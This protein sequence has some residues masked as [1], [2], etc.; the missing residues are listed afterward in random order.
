VHGESEGFM[1]SG[2]RSLTVCLGMS[3]LVPLFDHTVRARCA[4]Y[5]YCSTN[6][7]TIARPHTTYQLPC[8]VQLG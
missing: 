8:A 7:V 2:F 1:S 4:I 6:L 5:R 3:V